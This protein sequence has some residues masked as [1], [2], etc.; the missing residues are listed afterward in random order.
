[1]A[2][3]SVRYIIPDVFHA[4]IGCPFGNP[5]DN[6]K[7]N[8]AINL[9]I[10]IFNKYYK[11][12]KYSK[13]FFYFNSK[14]ESKITAE[15]KLWFSQDISR[16][17][18]GVAYCIDDIII[19]LVNAKNEID[20]SIREI[21]GDASKA[22]LTID[23]AIQ[24]TIEED[25]KKDSKTVAEY[26]NKAFNLINNNH[27]ENSF[28]GGFA[29][30][31]YELNDNQKKAIKYFID[32]PEGYDFVKQFAKE[33][34]SVMGKKFDVNG[35]F[36]SKHGIGL[37]IGKEINETKSSFDAVY[38][39]LNEKKHFIIKLTTKGFGF[40]DSDS[41]ANMLKALL[42]ECFIHGLLYINDYEN[43]K[44][45]NYDNIPNSI[46][47]PNNYVGL[48]PETDKS[49]YHHSYMVGV[50]L[51]DY[52]GKEFSAIKGKKYEMWPLKTFEILK[53]YLK[54]KYPDN[55][56]QDTILW[57]KGSNAGVDENNIIITKIRDEE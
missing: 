27:F 5:F 47:D 15:L 38:G 55:K 52:K 11:G 8:E 44:I 42:H 10:D 57:F 17:S 21:S 22:Y 18:N 46:K 43:D 31:E 56:I 7:G 26:I 33:G 51:K 48:Y 4:E 54:G 9:L 14:N 28:S 2:T 49:H 24:I 12:Q 6:G 37:I 13:E 20:I 23:N 29:V 53:T 3:S 36:Y 34:D 32:T 39:L 40:S 19:S 16:V 50:I 30:K 41:D 1:M 25:N 45:I 35:D